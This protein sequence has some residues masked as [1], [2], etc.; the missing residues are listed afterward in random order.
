MEPTT[1]QAPG[2]EIRNLATRLGVDLCV[3]T[4]QAAQL[5]GVAEQTMR[6]WASRGSGPIRPRRLG[7]L[8]RWAV[9]DINRVLADTAS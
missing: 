9:S 8:L 5:L 3:P 4:E 7:R 6:Q 1:G 2:S